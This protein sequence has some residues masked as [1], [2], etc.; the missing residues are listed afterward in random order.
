MELDHNR[1]ILRNAS[2]TV[3]KIALGG[4]A[5]FPRFC[6]GESPC[7]SSF[8]LTTDDLNPARWNEVLNPHLKKKPWY[9]LFG[10]SRR[11]AT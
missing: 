7:E 8:D 6:D 2:A 1:L 3:G 4:S 5:N 10:A 9:R 11:S